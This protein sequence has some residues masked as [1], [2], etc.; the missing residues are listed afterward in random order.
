MPSHHVI[1][2]YAIWPRPSRP[3]TRFAS[4]SAH[5]RENDYYASYNNLL[6]VLYHPESQFTVGPQTSE[7]RE[8][9]DYQVFWGE[10]PVFILGIKTG[11]NLGLMS[12][13]EEADLQIRRCLRD[14]MSICPPPRLHAFRAIC[15]KLCFYTAEDGHTEDCYRRSVH[16]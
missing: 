16:H 8:S 13:R 3:L 12:A 2:T 5:P 15:T 14:L 10:V 4:I 6:N 1:V 11:P 7:S 9:F